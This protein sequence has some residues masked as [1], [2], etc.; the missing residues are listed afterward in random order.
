M[1]PRS[2]VAVRSVG[3]LLLALIVAVLL[4]QRPHAWA[5]RV[6][7]LISFDGWRWDYLD[8]VPAPNLRALA[9]RGVRVR[10]LM[11]SFPSLTFPNHYTLVTGLYPAHHGIVSNDMEE[12]GFPH[13]S[14]SA[15]T[16][17]DPR[18]WG[19]QPIW[20]TA[21]NNG[22]H[23]ASMFWPGAEVP[24]EGT[25]P[26]YWQPFDDKYPNRDRVAKTLDWI[27]MPEDERPSFISLYFSDVD[28]AGHDYGPDSPELTRAVREVDG[29]LGDLVSGIHRLDADDWVDLVVVSDHGMTPVRGLVYLDDYID[30]KTI[31]V[32]DWDS[33]LQIAPGSA[34]VEEID[35]TLRDRL[36]HVRIYRKPEIPARLHY[37]DSARIPPIVGIADAGWI[38]TSHARQQ[39]RIADKKPPQRGQHGY[40]PAIRDMHALLVAAGPDIR[41]GVVVPPFENV[42]V[43]DFLCALLKLTPAPNDGDPAVARR[44]LVQGQ[45]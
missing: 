15:A 25:W 37:A 6:L 17:K 32:I 21:S 29:R 31:H 13:F 23:T 28:H 30:L 42:H 9:A 3:R 33:L 18:W 27:A 12:P 26:D 2:N 40:D 44:L 41:R 4:A 5:D 43:Y 45:P 35:R 38:V 11:P 1:G 16:A 20:V 34:S 24:I 22:L 19:G 39:K 14:M 10:E 7:V 36:P 8:R